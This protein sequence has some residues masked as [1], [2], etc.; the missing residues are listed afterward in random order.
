[1]LVLMTTKFTMVSL[2]L[3][4]WFIYTISAF[5]N[6][7]CCDVFIRACLY[8][9]TIFVFVNTFLKNILGSE[10]LIIKLGIQSLH[11]IHVCRLS[12][13]RLIVRK[14]TVQINHLIRTFTLKLINDANVK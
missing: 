11:S 7:F 3:D 13:S 12:S 6:K 4:R 2:I 8:Y 1:M 9:S 14:E 5:F 10:F